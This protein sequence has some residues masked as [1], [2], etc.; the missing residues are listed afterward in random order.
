MNDDLQKSLFREKKNFISCLEYQNYIDQF[1]KGLPIKINETECLTN[2]EI[3]ISIIEITI[4]LFKIS[5][6]AFNPI[7]TYLTFISFSFN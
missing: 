1:K 2:E 5:Q 6:I 7:L 3:S 4:I